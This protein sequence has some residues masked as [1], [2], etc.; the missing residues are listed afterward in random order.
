MLYAI[1]GVPRAGKSRLAGRLHRSLG[2][3]VLTT[4]AFIACFMAVAPEL[5]ID[6]AHPQRRKK[7]APGLKAA[8]HQIM[9]NNT[10]YV[11][12]GELLDPWLVRQLRSIADVRDCFLTM[13]EPNLATIVQ[14]EEANPW[15]VNLSSDEQQALLASLRQ[16]DRDVV[17]QCEA[18][19]A[20][21]F[22]VSSGDY[23]VVL[24]NAFDHLAGAA[25]RNV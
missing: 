7:I 20:P 12:E 24:G 23:E 1:G 9:S 3:S 4:D 22:D 25:P 17:A 5:G 10:H 11:L 2:I 14:N 16:L 8:V 19:E 13:S 18:F 6:Y 21:Y 15:V